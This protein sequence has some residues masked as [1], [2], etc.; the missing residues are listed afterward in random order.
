MAILHRSLSLFSTLWANVH[1]DAAFSLWQITDDGARSLGAPVM[2]PVFISGK[3]Y[4]VTVAHSMFWEPARG[5]EPNDTL[6][7][8]M[9]WCEVMY[10][11][12]VG[13]GIYADDAVGSVSPS[14]SF[15]D[16]DGTVHTYAME[17]FFTSATVPKGS[18][19][20]AG[21]LGGR[22][23][24]PGFDIKRRAIGSVLH[25]VQD[26]FARGHVKRTL[27]NPGDLAAPSSIDTYKPGKFGH[28]TDVENFHDY[29]SQKEDDHDK[30]DQ[31]A[32]R[33]DPQVLDSFN[34]IIGARDAADASV[35][36][37]D[38]WKTGDPWAKGQAPGDPA[39]Q[40]IR[41]RHPGR[42]HRIKG[43]MHQRAPRQW[44]N[45]WVGGDSERPLCMLAPPIVRPMDQCREADHEFEA[46]HHEAL[47]ESA[48]RSRQARCHIGGGRHFGRSRHRGR[49]EL[50]ARDRSVGRFPLV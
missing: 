37:L 26:S 30:N 29:K 43:L 40:I 46:D 14:T 35:K 4:S 31:V 12:S 34:P 17:T 36:I 16:A 11:L 6:A 48:T 18:V 10:R 8:I 45:G 41:R 38:R 2:V 33:P 22:T 49:S 24:F 3:T 13:D 20:F 15:T 19:T 50:A 39:V 5:E 9:L 42:R 47:A 28:W 1:G 25:L 7:K 23:A 32:S 27:S 44:A 21:L